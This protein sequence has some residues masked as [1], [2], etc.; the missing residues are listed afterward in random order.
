MPARS[1][2]ALGSPSEPCV[3]EPGIFAVLTIT[4]KRRSDSVREAPLARLPRSAA[5]AWLSPATSMDVTGATE[6]IAK[7]CHREATGWTVS[8]AAHPT[9][10]GGGGCCT[11]HGSWRPTV[12]SA[13]LPGQWCPG[14]SL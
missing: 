9:Q 13:G 12:R 4:A 14:L 11:E 3:K 8:G 1:I 5:G 7:R 6:P 2:R 10:A